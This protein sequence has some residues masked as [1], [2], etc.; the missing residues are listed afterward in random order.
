MASSFEGLNIVGH[1]K[2]GSGMGIP[3][4]KSHVSNAF[5]HFVSN[6]TDKVCCMFEISLLCLNMNFK[7][8][9]NLF[10]LVNKEDVFRQKNMK[11]VLLI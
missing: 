11:K 10:L 8:I 3:L 9:I 1:F 2:D 7:R 6:F 5:V 4:P